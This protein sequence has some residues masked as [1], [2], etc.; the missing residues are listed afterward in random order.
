V[1]KIALAPD[2]HG[3][4]DLAHPTTEGEICGAAEFDRLE[5]NERLISWGDGARLIG[6]DFPAQ[7]IDQPTPKDLNT[8]PISPNVASVIIE[9]RV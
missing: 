8:T 3:T 6:L 5:I 2:Y 1:G 4:C 7:N 9:L